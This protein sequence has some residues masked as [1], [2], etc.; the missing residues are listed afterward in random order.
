MKNVKHVI[1]NESYN[2]A[3]NIRKVGTKYYITKNLFNHSDKEIDCGAFVLGIKQVWAR[4]KY[5]TNHYI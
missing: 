5:E 2:K 3:L 1:Y 4:Q